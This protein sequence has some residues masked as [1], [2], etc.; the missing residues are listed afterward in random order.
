MISKMK[1]L[2]LAVDELHNCAR[3]LNGVADA[4]AALFGGDAETAPEQKVQTPTAQFDSPTEKP[5]TLE[6][7]RA[8]LAAKSRDGL[9][10]KVRELLL[11]HGAAKLSEIDPKEYPALLK[12]AE[13]LT[14]G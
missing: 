8:L 1:E 11:K 2:S 4:L 9:T 5:V 13:G 6:Q 7:V 3:A 14:D 10:D 12:E